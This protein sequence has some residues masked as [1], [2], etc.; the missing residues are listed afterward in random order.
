[1]SGDPQQRM[2]AMAKELLWRQRCIE[3]FP[4]DREEVLLSLLPPGVQDYVLDGSNK[5]TQWENLNHC[6]T[7]DR[8]VFVELMGRTGFAFWMKFDKPVISAPG[9][10]TFAMSEDNLHYDAVESWWER[11][12]DIHTELQAYQSAL[13]DFFS[14]ADH[15]QLVEKYWPEL[16]SFV[17]F[18]LL[19]SH[20]KPDLNKRRVVP[21]P[22]Q[23]HRDGIIE[24]LTASTL[25]DSYTCNAWVDYEAE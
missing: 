25:L 10:A 20:E 14:K 11:A 8:S 12:T 13:W 22:S 5:A 6:V 3:K 17:D 24:T 15:P 4:R 9:A 7:L 1:M 23:K 2:F 16:L 18:E 19:P 21:M